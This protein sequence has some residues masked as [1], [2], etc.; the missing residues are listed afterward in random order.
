MPILV[1]D[2]NW[3]QTDKRV[4][5]R[6]PLHGIHKSKADLLTTSN[7]IKASFEQFFCEIFLHRPI[8]YQASVCTF[9]SVEIVYEL[10]KV[11]CDIWDK[12][13]KDGLSK[14]EKREI[15]VKARDEE[16]T[17]L[18]AEEDSR[19]G[20][21]D[22]LRKCGISEAIRIDTDKRN[23]ID[24]IRKDEKLN[25]LGDVE[26]WRQKTK[27]KKLPKLKSTRIDQLPEPRNQQIIKVE[28]T[29]RVLPTPKRESQSVEEDEWLAKQAE[30][31]RSA[32]FVSE[33]LRDEEKNPDYLLA[34]GNEFLKNSNY[35]GAISAYSFGVEISPNFI[36]FY[37]KRSEVHFIVKNYHRCIKDCSE[38]LERLIPAV[39]AN[40][41]ER[42][43]CI[44]R[45]G[46]AL[47]KVGMKKQAIDELKASLK[48]ERISLFEDYLFHVLNEDEESE[49]EG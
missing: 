11:D 41:K 16:E 14:A 13:E 36:Q 2:F 39:A 19:R 22:S 46:C 38:A 40:L 10:V 24:I 35:L 17:R 44:G 27:K 9:N 26:V 3:R 8:D 47:H 21:A 31:R 6:V 25:A 1:T 18:K 29:P 43:I 49:N 7:Y 20:K 12:L 37:I 23:R 42:A 28:F 4:T 30:A 34:K 32:G 45:R 33:D 15:R 5:I 48:L